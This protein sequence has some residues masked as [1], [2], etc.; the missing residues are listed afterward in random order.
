MQCF[1]ILGALVF[2]WYFLTLCL[3]E[4]A[5]YSLIMVADAVWHQMFIEN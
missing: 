2:L 4:P 5:H 3:L 1:V